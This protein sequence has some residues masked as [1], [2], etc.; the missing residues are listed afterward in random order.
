MHP[1]YSAC[2]CAGD[3]VPIFPLTVVKDLMRSLLSTVKKP[4][5]VGRW[6][7]SVRSQSNT[8][9]LPPSSV[10]PLYSDMCGYI[11]NRL[12]HVS[13]SYVR[14]VT[15]PQLLIISNVK[16]MEMIGLPGSCVG[17]QPNVVKH[18][19]TVCWDVLGAGVVG[20]PMCP[21][22]VLLG[23]LHWLDILCARVCV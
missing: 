23:L 15:L 9:A 14:G 17:C 2:A 21:V 3:E 6:G 20:L 7:K 16:E 12:S 22:K 11:S 13:T 19:V 5:T 18:C 4:F 1:A 10:S 8:S